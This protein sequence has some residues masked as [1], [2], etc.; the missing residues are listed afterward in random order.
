MPEQQN[1]L[2]GKGERL[3]ED[4][5][6]GGRKMDRSPPYTFE[7]A[8]DRLEPMLST[9]AEALGNLP[10]IACP[11][12]EVVSSLTLN[13][14]Y[15]A[16]S[17]YPDHLF[18]NF[19]LR[20]VGSRPARVTPERRSKGREPVEKPTTELFVAGPKAS[21]RRL[22]TEVARL[23]PT[24]YIAKDLPAVENFTPLSAKSK[25]KSIV[26]D[27]KELPLEVVLH[28]TE[29][30]SDSYILEGFVKY[31]ETLELSVDLDHRFHAGGLCFMR[32]TAPRE[33]LEAIASF[34]FLR[35][36]R[37]M[38]RLRL[39]QPLLRA[40]KGTLAQTSLPN[41]PGIDP[42]LRVAVFDGGV[43]DTSPLSPWVTGYDPPGI[44]AAVPDYVAHGYA[45]TSALLFGPLQAGAEAPRPYVH[46]DHY[47]VL[48]ADSGNDPLELFDVLERIKNTLTT[49]P[50][51]DFINFSIGPRLPID[52]DDV[53]AWT[54]VLDEYLADGETLAV[55][56]VGN[57]GERDTA[58]R[59]DRVQV[60]SD[61]VNALGVGACGTQA[62]IWKRAP[63]SSVGP[64]RSPGLIKPD[65]VAFGGC[66]TEPYCVLSPTTGVALV[67]QCGTSFAAPHTLR[68][69]T[70]IKAHFGSMLSP[71]AIRTLL[72]HAAEESAEPQ[73]EVGW[74][75]VRDNLDDIVVCPP[76]HIRVV[77]QGEITA[78][79][80]LR[81]EIP[82]P[83]D[84]LQ[85]N[86][87]ITA[88]C[89]FATDIDSAHPGNY[90]RSGIEITFRPN[91]D[92]FNGGA[93]HP[94]SE[95]FFSQK[96]FGQ[97]EDELRSDAHK[98]ETC[99]HA[100]KKKR[101]SSLKRPVFDI[102]YL[103]RDE[104][105]VDNQSHK[106]KYAL[107]VTVETPRHADIYDLVVRKYRSVLE[108]LTPVVQV[109]IRT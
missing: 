27:K 12:G 77:F 32:M 39:L 59:L 30:R 63:Y 73:H 24:G 44:G 45:V 94:K 67:P 49:S 41:E 11:R 101:A 34:S 102:H 8:R 92:H 86:V 25:I 57:D 4:I 38:P 65:I 74:G 61:C 33:K 22:A 23:D 47:R 16:K 100:S 50:R 2:L 84:A 36:V 10:P 9:M 28:A 6:P 95:P 82:L 76:G 42:H 46:A 19:G 103:A 68:M 17:Y 48:D 66:E 7:E 78:S 55:V 106:L 21:F 43:P 40:G 81:A 5:T 14:E 69:G 62:A 29:F 37:E 58:T 85:G 79:K 15:I 13:P 98:W 70:A 91:E 1:F 35:A 109:P 64:G 88:T 97:S 20:A 75:R 56:A 71:L 72:I 104:G 53:H 105:H 96:A 107:V 60:P 90:T 26:S 83:S 31:L 87:K 52:D 54:A 108:P 99:L 51:Y 80:Y 89:C 18:K 3:T 93:L